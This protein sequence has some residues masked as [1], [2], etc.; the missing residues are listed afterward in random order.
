[1]RALIVSACCSSLRFKAAETIV[2][3]GNVDGLEKVS[4]EL[5]LTE[6]LTLRQAIIV[7]TG[8]DVRMLLIVKDI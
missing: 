4:L 7:K 5:S 2:D 8:I 1:M 3:F 6:L